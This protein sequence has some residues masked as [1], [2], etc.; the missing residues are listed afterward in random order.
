MLYWASLRH[1]SVKQRVVLS[2]PSA[3]SLR[4]V[5][6]CAASGPLLP[7]GSVPVVP[8][9]RGGSLLAGVEP[10]SFRFEPVALPQS[11][12]PMRKGTC[13]ALAIDG[14]HVHPPEISAWSLISHQPG[15]LVSLLV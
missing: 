7:G 8:G 10:G 11:Q 12:G 9:G 5:C 3:L 1:P 14:W 6:P 15:A 4:L 2:S 13:Q